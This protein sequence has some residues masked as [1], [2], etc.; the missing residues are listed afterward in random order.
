MKS[1]FKKSIELNTKIEQFIDTISD[2]LMLLEKLIGNY[3]AGDHDT[4][5]ETIERI[6]ALESDADAI[7]KEIK[8]S[9]YT[10]ML[11][12][13]ARADV[14]SLVKSLDNIIDITEEIAKDIYMQKP[15][16]PVQVKKELMDLTKNTILSAEQLL[17]ATRAFFNEAHLATSHINKIV[18]YEHEADILQDKLVDMLFNGSIVTKLS[19]KMHLKGFVDKIASISDEAE[20]I[21]EKLTVFTVK[22]EI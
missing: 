15:D 9:L 12:P 20:L 8:V 13:D 19:V 11:I 1:V 21:G 16:F 14:I 3:L 22:R 2:G 18:F 4:F 6:C 7:G 17:L 5:K 10:F